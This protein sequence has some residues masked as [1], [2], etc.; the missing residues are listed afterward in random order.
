MKRIRSWALLLGMVAVVTASA[1]LPPRLSQARDR[2]FFN[3]VNAEETA[4]T[5][6]SPADDLTK[7]LEL[8]ARWSSGGDVAVDAG[9]VDFTSEVLPMDMDKEMD[10]GSSLV[11]HSSNLE[12]RALEALHALAKSVPQI[13]GRFPQSMPEIHGERRIIYDTDQSGM[14]ASYIALGWSEKVWFLDLTIDETTEKVLSLL[15]SGPELG[16]AGDEEREAIA[17][18]FLQYLGVTGEESGTVL[19]D[20][21]SYVRLTGTDFYYY[22]YL[23][24]TLLSIQPLTVLPEEDGKQEEYD[25]VD[26]DGKPVTRVVDRK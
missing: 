25:I 11:A 3:H 12:Q 13:E 8:L 7:R 14:A 19:E 16:E 10:Q 9:I 21:A 18:A 15:L 5:L 20:K 26:T 24:P 22:V 17:R 4:D 1:V 23:T 6:F 2:E